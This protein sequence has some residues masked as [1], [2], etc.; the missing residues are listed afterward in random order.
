MIKASELIALFWVAIN[1]IWGYIWGTAGKQWT[2]ALQNQKINYMVKNFGS[3]W[4]TDSEA[5]KN[6][7]YY[8]ALYGAKWIGH[9]VADCSGLF[10][11]AFAKL[12]GA[13]AHGSNSIWDR[14]CTSKGKLAGGKRTDGMEL[15][16]GTAVFV[17]KSGS[18]RTHI[19]LYVGD[20]TV[21]EA[22][23]AQKGV[24]TS[25]ITDKKWAEWGE[26]KNV[27]YDGTPLPDVKPVLKKGDQGRYVTLAQTELI[28]KGYSCGS[29]GADGKFGSATEAA[30]K[31][32]QTD[33]QI[34][35]TGIINQE[36]WEALDS[37]T[38]TTNLYTV[39]I[40]HLT[41]YKAEALVRQYAGASMIEE[42]R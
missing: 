28:Q 11:W 22:A 36:T 13:I 12:G 10:A 1:E 20:G 26:L 30:V 25:A 42:G 34:N 7:Y 38:P 21:I 31:E 24:I 8:S 29:Y 5:K 16:P 35:P 15:R 37:V 6:K 39:S 19:G 3:D 2:Q 27:E 17:N 18:D 40:P 4:K 32:F 23:S 14:Y 9:M 41:Y 33:H